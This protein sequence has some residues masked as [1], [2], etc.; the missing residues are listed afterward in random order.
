MIVKRHKKIGIIVALLTALV[1]GA[2]PPA[3]RA[4]Y[5]DGGNATFMLLAAMF[6]RTFIMT[7]FCLVTK[8]KLFTTK[9][10]RK[11]A[12]TGGFFQ[13]AGVLGIFGALNYLPG[14]IVLIIVFT[15]TLMLLFFMAWKG[16][17]K[18]NMPIIVTTFTALIGLSLA[19]NVWHQDAPLSLLGMGLALIAALTTLSRLYLYGKQTLT[20]HPAVLGAETFII[21]LLIIIAVSLFFTP[22]LPQHTDTYWWVAVACLSQ[23]LGTFGMFYGIALLGSFEFSLISKIEPIFTALFSVLFIHEILNAA[24]YGGIVLVLGSLMV[25]QY[26]EHRKQSLSA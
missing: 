11:M 4:V 8:K 5:A 25:Y 16:E 22:H 17:L 1:Y 23:A 13:A 15:H 3:I 2:Y 12:L 9:A 21:A 10:D 26:L 14:P 7:A 6:A 20:K 19:L 24:Q 18:L